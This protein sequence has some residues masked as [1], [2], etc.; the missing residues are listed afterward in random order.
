MEIKENMSIPFLD[1]LIMRKEDGSIGH[2]VFRKSTHT[3]NYLHVD[4][5]HH[6]TQELGVLNTLSIRALR[7]SD[8]DHLNEEK[9]HLVSTF[10]GIGYKEKGD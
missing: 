5:H 4:S 1:I 8:A 7:I 6:P 9:K 3:E 2:K 10:K